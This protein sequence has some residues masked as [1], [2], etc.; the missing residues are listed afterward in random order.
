MIWWGSTRNFFQW[1]NSIRSVLTLSVLVIISSV[2]VSTPAPKL[3]SVHS[4]KIKF[5][6]DQIPDQIKS[7]QFRSHLVP[8]RWGYDLLVGHLTL[9][10]STISLG[11]CHKSTISLGKC[12]KCMQ[13]EKMTNIEHFQRLQATKHDWSM[14]LYCELM[15]ELY[16]EL[17]FE[18][19][20]ELMFELYCELMP[21]NYCGSPVIIRVVP[22][23]HE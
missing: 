13:P 1:K 20:C 17:M 9:K 5:S 21:M 12:H 15:F 3:S 18:L 8:S 2:S 4:M 23:T 10:R 7:D 22:P 6:W 19:Y 16:C 14:M 11:K